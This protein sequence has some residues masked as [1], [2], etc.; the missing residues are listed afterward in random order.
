MTFAVRTQMYLLIFLL[1]CLLNKELTF[2]TDGHDFKIDIY[3]S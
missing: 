1:N 3:H 2:F